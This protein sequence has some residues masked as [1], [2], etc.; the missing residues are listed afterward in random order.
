L[1]LPPET[2]PDVTGEPLTVKVTVPELIV[3]PLA[4]ATAAVRVTDVAPNVAAAVEAVVVVP[5]AEA[6]TTSVLDPSAVSPD[7]AVLVARTVNGVDPA[8]VAAVVVIVSVDVADGIPFPKLTVAGLNDAVAPA[9]S[10]V[11]TESAALNAPLTLV[12]R[13]TVTGNVTL[14]GVPAESVPACPPTETVPTRFTR[15]VNVPESAEFEF[16]Q[17]VG[18]ACTWNVNEPTGVLPEVETFRLEVKF[19]FPVTGLFPKAAEAPA[20]SPVSLPAAAALSVTV[21]ALALPV[22]PTLTVP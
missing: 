10:D 19:A 20:G 3:G 2:V 6:P 12:K 9:G 4:G 14:F 15:S 1:A 16:W 11:T 5:I 21:H 18:A 13:S 7:P 22:I 17:L 8:G